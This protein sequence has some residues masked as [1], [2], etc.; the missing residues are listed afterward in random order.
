MPSKK[1]R[2]LL[3]A[4]SA[5]ESNRFRKYLHSPYFNENE[6]LRKLYEALQAFKHLESQVEGNNL[7]QKQVIWQ[8]LFEQQP[9]DDGQ[10]RRLLSELTQHALHFIALEKQEKQVV[11][12]HILLLDIM[13]DAD[14][15][16]H[17]TG[18]LR[19][20]LSLQEKSGLRNSDFHFYQYLIEEKIYQHK[21][22][23]DRKPEMLQNLV[24]ADFHLDC[25]Y[26][27]QKLK[28]YCSWL[29]YSNIFSTALKFNL[30]SHFL[31]WIKSSNYLS[32]PLN[33]AYFILLNLLLFPEQE[34]YYWDLKKLLTHKE[35]HFDIQEMR[36]FYF[37]LMN[38]CIDKKINSGKTDFFTELF[39][40]FTKSLKNNILLQKGILPPSYYKNII[41]TAI[42]VQEFEW[43]E[44]FL[45]TYTPKLPPEEQANALTYN[46][47]QVYFAQQRYEKVIEQ[48]REVEYENLTYALGGKLMLLKTYYELSE[49]LALDS[50]ID[51]FR[52]YL[53]RNKVISKEVRQQYLNVLQFV[54][55]LSNVRL[56]TPSALEKIEQQVKEAKNLPLKSWIVEK[57][58]ELKR[59]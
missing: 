7:E 13:K 29:D 14:L 25:Y 46:L 21:E 22:K 58:E 52:I 44:S 48:L 10:I 38:Y 40:L 5:H 39:S 35:Q 6:T 9:Y 47:A 41:A 16:L 17:F 27:S 50:L 30:P 43:T 49:Y 11:K 20:T 42:R 34:N 51:S 12:E 2:T 8:M 36:I 28:H 1:L 4:F 53:R 23:V 56:G 31:D 3:G 19:Q 59:S 45:Q 24:N 26:I 55:K 32:E 18:V 57:V 54:K 33:E 15:D 37:A